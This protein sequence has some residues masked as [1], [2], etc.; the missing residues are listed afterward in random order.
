MAVEPFQIVNADGSVNMSEYNRCIQFLQDYTAGTIPVYPEVT[1][2]NPLEVDMS[3]E[4]SALEILAELIL[5]TN[6]KLLNKTAFNSIYKLF[7]GILNRYGSTIHT[8]GRYLDASADFIDGPGYMYDVITDSNV[9][10]K[11]SQINADITVYYLDDDNHTVLEYADQAYRNVIPDTVLPNCN[12]PLLNL[13]SNT[14]TSNVSGYPNLYHGY[15]CGVYSD[16]QR[17]AGQYVGSSTLFY[18][19]EC[20]DQLYTTGGSSF[21]DSRLHEILNFN[22]RTGVYNKSRPSRG[23]TLSNVSS[24]QNQVVNPGYVNAYIMSNIINTEVNYLSPVFFTSLTESDW[25]K[26]WQ[27]ETQTNV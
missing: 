23:I 20:N 25:I 14:L 21:S 6:N 18:F 1:W 22:Y 12:Y 17:M 9:Q 3:Q 15:L 8:C 5:F 7:Q 27:D 13:T 16:F 2:T 4:K 19:S 24:I 10:V 26:T 11:T